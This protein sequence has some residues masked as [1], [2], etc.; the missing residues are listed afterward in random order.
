MFAACGLFVIRFDNRDVG[1]S[2]SFADSPVGDQGQA[3]LINDMAADAIAVLDAE[4]RASAPMHC[5]RSACR[6]W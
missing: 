4:G 2:T 6:R 3:Y 5:V 1:L